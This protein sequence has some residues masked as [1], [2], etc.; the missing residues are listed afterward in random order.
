[1]SWPVIRGLGFELTFADILSAL[2]LTAG[3][4]ALHAAVTGEL[5][6]AV[7][8]VIAGV[9]FD[10]FDGRIARYYKQAHPFG[11]EIDS[12]ADLVSFGLAPGVIILMQQ[13]TGIVVAAASV[14]A[15]AAAFRL[16]RFNIEQAH[17]KMKHYRGLPVPAAAVFALV[18]SFASWQ[19]AATVL[20]LLSVFMISTVRVPK[21]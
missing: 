19:I 8:L 21:P 11:R 17:G 15:I 1:M 3:V 9:L 10:F 14:Y 13:P 6:S 7:I 16:A 18:A 20:L 2:N 12:L 4:L 5:L